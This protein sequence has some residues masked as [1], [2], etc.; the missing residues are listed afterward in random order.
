MVSYASCD[1]HGTF[2][3]A[4]AEGQRLDNPELQRTGRRRE[5]GD[6]SSRRLVQSRQVC[7]NRSLCG[8][9]VR[10]TLS[11]DLVER[12]IVDILETMETLMGKSTF[13]VSLFL[14]SC[15]QMADTSDCHVV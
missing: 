11:E 12:L 4:Y 3:T 14:P 7:A 8:S 9:P 1:I 15:S 5:G 2:F 10:E 13:L 6:A